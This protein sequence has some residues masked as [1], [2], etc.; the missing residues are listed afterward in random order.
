MFLN[1]MELSPAIFPVKCLKR[2]TQMQKKLAVLLMTMF[3]LNSS[4]F[5]QQST[6]RGTITDENAN[7]LVGATVAISGSNTAVV[8]DANGTFSINAS[9][10][11]TLEISYV[12]K[13][14]QK[15]IVGKNPVI[16]VTLKNQT[17]SSLEEVVVT[18]YMSQKKADLTG[19]VAVVSPK[20]LSKGHGVTNV[21]QSLQ[22]VVPGLHV[23]TD[24][25]PS[26][27][28]GIQVRGLTSING[29]NPLIVIDGVPS[30]M[31]L[32]D[33]NPDNI[34]S[35]QVLKDAYSASIYG[36]QG[37]SGVILIQTKQGRPGKA[38]IT[39][40]GSYGVSNW[41]NRPQMLNTIQYGKALWQ[42]AVNDG[43]DPAAVTQIYTYDWHKDGNGIP[44]LETITPRKYLNADSTMIGAN[45]NWLDA[46]SQNGIQNN[47]QI[48]ISG[49]NEKATSYLSL[50]F[51]QNEGTQIYTGFKRFTAR[52][53]TDYKVINDHFT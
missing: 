42:A 19:A 18:G 23:T 30:Y 36:T 1:L 24:G 35:M 20:E 31:N 6:V 53:N 8:T 46:I 2:I 21:M 10:G 13:L 16:N 27:N 52:V 4:L 15:I 43:Q 9:R 28:V 38:K 14:D 39:Y 37:G 44:I 11:Q 5:A 49:G 50:N 32:R 7:P 34:A 33:I 3:L 48:S 17:E 51:L 40:N 12:G 29:S 26:G 45:T 22:G 47:H 41:N 25:N